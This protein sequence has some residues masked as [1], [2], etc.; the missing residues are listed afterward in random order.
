MP[1][2]GF[3]ALFVSATATSTATR[4]FQA[5]GF[6]FCGILGSVID[7]ATHKRTDTPR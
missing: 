5:E 7:N 4:I 1:F 6:Q 2:H 3:L